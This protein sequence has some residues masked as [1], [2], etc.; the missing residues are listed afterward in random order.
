MPI[1]VAGTSSKRPSSGF[2]LLELVV[3]LVILAGVAALVAPRLVFLQDMALRN[4]SRRVVTLL[5]Y[6]DERAVAT[7][8][9]YRLKINLDEKRIAVVQLTPLGEEQQPDD[10]FLQRNP[11]SDGVGIIDV[12]T[13][14][15][16]K[17]ADGSV[18]IPYGPGG[19]GEPFLLHLGAIDKK[20]FTIQALPVS[21]TVRLAEGY[22]ESFK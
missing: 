15:L 5:R 18:S 4:S 12:T 21:A 9:Y 20:Q 14:R 16:G 3:V 10:P 19:L 1:S 8:R 7:K 6:L 11:L 22:Q 13:N 2:T 17:T